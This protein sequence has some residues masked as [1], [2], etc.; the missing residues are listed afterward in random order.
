MWLIYV[1]IKGNSS[2]IL[3]GIYREIQYEGLA[4]INSLDLKLLPLPEI[5][6]INIASAFLLRW[7][8]ALWSMAS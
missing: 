5:Q 1:I 6:S 7:A 4:R 3:Q 2:S 8:R